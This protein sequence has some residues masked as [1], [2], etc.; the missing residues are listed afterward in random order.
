MI[1]RPDT[2][3]LLQFE[4]SDA[5][6]ALL[7]TTTRNGGV[8]QPPFDTFNL[9]NFSD[10]NPAD[11]AENRRHLSNTL[12]IK[13]NRL[14]IP[15][16]VHGDRIVTIDD[17]FL[18]ASVTEQ[19]ALI[20]GCDALITNEPD[21]C[22]GVTTADCVPI[23]L[24]DSQ[25]RVAAAIHA[26]WRSTVQKIVVKTV[27]EMR[28]RFGVSSANLVA[29]IG[30]AIGQGAFEVGNEVVDAFREAGLLYQTA[31][32]RHPETGKAHLNLSEINRLQLTDCGIKPENIETSGLC[33]H[34]RGDLFFSARRQGIR[35]GRMVTGVV[36]R[37]VTPSGTL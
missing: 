24:Y 17:S 15:K 3:F 32:T 11:I 5:H 35:S 33:T 25:K 10:D 31:H 14:F 27:E 12:G 1:A 36:I 7:F 19:T 4:C 13:P 29:A 37:Q 2:P 16:Q 9:G 20:E 26:G 34:T 28:R 23:L 18:S 30:P 21:I 8:S 6:D 22:I